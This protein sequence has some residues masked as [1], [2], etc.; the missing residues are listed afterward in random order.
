MLFRSVSQS[1]Y[2]GAMSQIA[3]QMFTD[4]QRTQFPATLNLGGGKT[5]T[6]VGG[7]NGSVDT[8]PTPRVAEANCASIGARLPTP[9]EYEA[10]DSYGDWSGGVSLNLKVWALAGNKVYAAALTKPSPVRDV[11]EVNNESF[12]YYCVQ[13]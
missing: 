7:M 8:A 6:I 1:R 3:S 2:A 10:A 4:F 5:L 11:S 12:L 13:Q 9:A